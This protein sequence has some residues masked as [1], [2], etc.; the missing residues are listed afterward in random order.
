[1]TENTKPQKSIFNP[2]LEL[3]GWMAHDY[4]PHNRGLVWYIVFCTIIFGT[5]LWSLFILK[6]WIMS[7]V[8]FLAAAVYF[9]VHRKG[10]EDHTVRI[11]ENGLLIDDQKFYNWKEFSG[12]WFL[13]DETISVINFQIAK[14]DQKIPLQLGELDPETIRNVLK[15]VDLEELEDQTEPLLDLWIR[16]LK[17]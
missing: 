9:L 13:Y 6:D 7:L 16:G 10:N 11:F 2:G 17:L 3:F 4:H 5:A 14:K 12:F 8:L 1:M 15:Q